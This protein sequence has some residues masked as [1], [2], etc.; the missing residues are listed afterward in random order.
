MGDEREIGFVR[1]IAIESLETFAEIALSAENK[2]MEKAPSNAESFAAINTFTSTN[3]LKNKSNTS[4]ANQESYGFLS[5]E[6]AIARVVVADESGQ[7]FVYYFCRATA[8][9]LA[10]SSKTLAGY[11]LPIGRLAELSI[12]DDATVVR[13]GKPVEVEIIEQAKFLPEQTADGWDAI[14]AVLEGDDIGPLTIKSLRAVL[15]AQEQELNADL[16][17]RLLAEDAASENIRDGIR[18]RVVSNMDLRDQPILDRH[19]GEI[20]RLPLNSQLLIL[21]APGTGK[22][23]T[24]VRRLGQKLDFQFLKEEEQRLLEENSKAD[25]AYSWIMF[26]PTELLKLYVKE[27]FNREGIPAPDARIQ[28]W[29]EFRADLARNTFGILKT[30][31]NSSSLVMKDEVPTLLP[32]TF[33]DEIAWF[34]DFDDWQRSLFWNELRQEAQQLAEKQKESVRRIGGKL[35]RIMPAEGSIPKANAVAELLTIAKEIKDIADRMKEDTDRK[36]RGALNLQVN[37]NKAFLDELATK[38]KDIGDDGDE[39]D[40]LEVVEEE[41]PTQPRAG[42]AAAMARYIQVMRTLSRSRANKRSIGQAS[43]AGQLIKWLGDRTL[44][45]DDQAS[46]GESLVIQSSLRSFSNPIRRYVDGVVSRY[47]RFRRSRQAENLWYLKKGFAPTDIHPLEVD[48]VILSI[49]RA[50]DD[51]IRTG[52]T[53]NNDGPVPAALERM[54]GLFRTQVAVDEATDFS[55][56]QLACMA[57]LARPGSRSFF[58]C[59]D[60]NQRVTPWGAHSV[61]DVRWAVPDIQTKKITI[62]YRQS[63]RLYELAR[64]LVALSGGDP[65]DAVLPK[66]SENEGM[67]PVLRTQLADTAQISGWLRERIMEIETALGTLPSIAV[68]VNSEDEVRSIATDLGNA[69]GDQNINVI[70]CPDG[71]VKGQDGAV[72][73]FNVQH[74]KGLEFE[75]VFFVGVDRLAENRPTLFDKYLYVGATRAATYLGLTCET[76]LPASISALRGHFGNNWSD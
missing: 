67:M 19:Q 16:L 20:F 6:P 44:D 69:L 37:H 8:I 41:E 58:A 60:F 32:A 23:T 57:T 43:S 73:V 71:Q 40:D 64:Q 29:N 45:L 50:S 28:T 26:T 72:R 22:T 2:M 4:K 5:R 59:G 10:S 49:L 51:L 1:P 9:S 42:R 70:P 14:N 75:A 18:R 68:L 54:E 30:S 15:L 61:D 24:L 66:F 55:P 63:G 76:D 38:I 34:N 39:P 56:V 65:S 3:A 52:V 62:A 17:D 46:V 48:I 27:A 11:R 36:I 33:T 47:R 35:N 31:A 12:G 53:K 21:G 25:H 13:N 7:R 74:I